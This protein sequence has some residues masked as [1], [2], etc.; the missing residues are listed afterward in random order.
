MDPQD[1]YY[2]LAHEQA[3]LSRKDHIFKP[4]GYFLLTVYWFHPILWMGY[5][6]FCRDIE[7]AC[8]EKVIKTLGKAS[9]KAYSQA[10]INCSVPKRSIAACPLAFGEIG[11]KKRVKA[12]LHYRKPSF[13]LLLIAV[14][15]IAT[16]ALCFL[17][18]PKEPAAPSESSET[19]ASEESRL[20]ITT[21][22]ATPTRV[23]VHFLKN[24]EVPTGQETYFLLPGFTLER[25]EGDRWILL[26]SQDAVT[27]SQP[28]PVRFLTE[29]TDSNSLV[30]SWD[31]LEPLTEGR[32]RL[33]LVVLPER[34]V[35]SE[36]KLFLHSEFSIGALTEETGMLP[37]EDLPPDYSAEEADLDGCLV[38]A[39]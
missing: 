13:F 19:A 15:L 3:H 17:T 36:E 10:L 24:P 26:N 1:Q 35:E 25:Q 28:E 20:F 29:A 18:D 32:Y 39:E 23:L 31:S 4:L 14:I 12:I 11:V 6:V 27:F 38:L 37:F 7:L 5:L 9:K 33:G 2:V 22:D 21:S 34:D 16:L 8:D 30:Y